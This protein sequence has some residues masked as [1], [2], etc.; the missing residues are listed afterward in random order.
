MRTLQR[1]LLHWLLERRTV[2][3]GG[4]GAGLIRGLQEVQQDPIGIASR[5]NCVV[6]K[7]ELAEFGM[8]K[9]L[10]R[11]DSRHGEAWRFGIDV[12]VECRLREGSSTGPPSRADA[13][14]RIRFS[15][16]PV[17]EVRHSARMCRSLP[18]RKSGAREI[19][20]APEK[21]NRTA[22][23][24]KPAAKLLE[25]SIR[26]AQDCPAPVRVLGI[27]RGM[28]PIFGKGK[29]ILHLGRDWA[30]PDFQV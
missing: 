15:R 18:S 12:G 1:S 5:P 9:G 6:R 21:M 22:L 25:H 29:R 30:K 27:V 7:D 10:C 4:C 16:H 26:M 14:M 13:F 3:F 24:D 17:G 8:V 28:L 11:S 2:P 20:A 19:K 23:A